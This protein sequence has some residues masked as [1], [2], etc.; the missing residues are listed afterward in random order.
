M[1]CQNCGNKV[2]N[3]TIKWIKGKKIEFCKY[4][5]DGYADILD[6]S[7]EHKIMSE[8]SHCSI[9]HLKDIKSRRIDF[10]TGE[11]YRDTKKKYFI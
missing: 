6:H 11:V 10:N 8:I 7:N 4:C 5:Q 2:H 1:I 9:A 3:I